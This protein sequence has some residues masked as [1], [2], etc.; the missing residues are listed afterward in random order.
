M[1]QVYNYFS[2]YINSDDLAEIGYSEIV[3]LKIRRASRT[4][5]LGVL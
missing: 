5:E 1:A 3:S 2:N 4:V